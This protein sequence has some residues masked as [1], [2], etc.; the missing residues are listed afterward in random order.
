MAGAVDELKVR[1]EFTA[2][3]DRLEIRA[4]SPVF[5]SDHETVE[6]PRPDLDQQSKQFY[7]ARSPAVLTSLGESLYNLLLT[8]KTGHIAE[9]ALDHASRA[10]TA[11]LFEFGFYGDQVELAR[12]PWEV[13]QDR[14]RRFLVRD[15][16]V[17]VIRT[18]HY[19]LPLPEFNQSLIS[20]PV[21]QV[22]SSPKDLAPLQAIDLPI[23]H[24]V[25]RHATFAQFQEKLLFDYLKLCGVQ[26]DG[27][28]GILLQC[29]NCERLNLNQ[30]TIC[31]GCRS[32]L[33]GAVR[34]GGLAFEHPDGTTHLVAARNVGSMFNSVEA[35]F[36]LLLACDTAALS[37][38]DGF[39]SLASELIL[40][41]VPVV[42]GMQ[43]RVKDSFANNFAASFYMALRRRPDVLEAVRLARRMNLQG[44]WYSPA[45]YLRSR[46]NTPAG[47]SQRQFTA[48]RSIDTAAPRRVVVREPFLA[49]LW[50]RR[51]QT[52][53]LSEA[54][55]R[56]SLD[57]PPEAE[58]Q[59]QAAQAEIAQPLELQTEDGR[60][61]RRGLVEVTLD[62][63]N[64]QVRP[65][66]ITLFIDE[67]MDA[68][69]A[70]FTVECQK[71]GSL[72]L[73]FNIW[74]E[75][76]LVVSVA[77]P[78]Q[79]LPPDAEPRAPDIQSASAS[80]PVSA[81]E[82][83]LHSSNLVRLPADV[84][85][86]TRLLAALAYLNRLDDV[87]LGQLCLLYYP[88][89]Y[90]RFSD[91]MRRD[92]KIELL[93][94]HFN[95]HPEE[96]SLLSLA[97]AAI[98]ASEPPQQSFHLFHRL[99][100]LA[101]DLA[102][103]PALRSAAG[104]ESLLRTSVDE[105]T[106]ESFVRSPEVEDDLAL[107]LA[108][109]ASRR[110]PDGEPALLALLDQALLYAYGFEV[111]ERL[112]AWRSQIASPPPPAL[113]ELE[114]DDF[115]VRAAAARRL[116]EQ[117]GR[118]SP[119]WALEDL[120]Q[121]LL[122]L[123]SDDYPQVRLAAI[124]ALER[125]QPTGEWRAK[126]V[127]ECYVPA[128]AFVMGDDGKDWLGNPV[129]MHE[130]P[131]DAFYIG[132]YPV[133]NRE[134]A[135]FMAD[136]GKDFEFEAGK[137]RHPVV[138]VAWYDA[139]DYCAWAGMRLPS[140]AEWEKAAS[141]EPV[142]PD[143]PAALP[144]PSRSGKGAGGIGKKR[145]FPWGDQFDPER[146]NTWESRIRATTE[147]GRYSPA[148]DRPYGC[149][150]RAGNVWEWTG[151][152]Y[153][154]YPYQAGDGREAPDS[155]ASRVLRGGAFLDD[156]GLARCAYRLRVGPLSRADNVGFRVAAVPSAL[157]PGDPGPWGPGQ[158]QP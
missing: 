149:A 80:V 147:V 91:G 85:R 2:L 58:L 45:V 143:H 5:D 75:G 81:G 133:T 99:P 151:S 136:Q 52:P 74:Q 152:L 157:D 144:P 19:P 46:R 123:L 3:Q 142:S 9:Q 100:D 105:Y 8:G 88:G 28:G 33:A 115:R 131:L 34:V 13:L 42:V 118:E 150:D 114:A 65:D 67:D 23:N 53:P 94:A 148:G 134:Y 108:Q 31:S 66:K 12:Y 36:A 43:T 15:G 153:Q 101:G 102:R 89:V 82:V 107:I 141:W 109:A 125:L 92:K 95:Y 137:E 70:I 117:A 154:P 86:R 39:N 27:H 146:C 72:T 21:L 50:I 103:L 127:F 6:W 47:A 116:G 68:P 7:I 44:E 49:R 71:T 87:Q 56:D 41:G 97:R 122:P 130:V 139:R 104:R 30:A 112:A 110:S 93:L 20:H 79:S 138:I 11:A 54:A 129:P 120:A 90:E 113:A 78:L 145:R 96:L 16:L 119:G 124:Q 128:G 1:F 38:Q 57:L 158:G 73:R 18:I 29:A 64:C 69:D 14:Y 111:G 4:I 126:L 51:P 77:Q 26:F 132:K 84:D 135:R 24:T 156:E 121:A 10:K 59:T 25:L 55:L 32:S 106:P 17:D 62:A 155:F 98:F 140:E 37:G 35:L 63:R 61:F 83:E 60:T 22:F 48:R 40:S 76:G